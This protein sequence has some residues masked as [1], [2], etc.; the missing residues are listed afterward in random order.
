MR[1]VP[2]IDY[3]PSR[4]HQP[5]L[6]GWPSAWP[7][8]LAVAAAFGVGLVIPYRPLVTAGAFVAILGLSLILLY[9]REMPR[10]FLM[11]LGALL[12][13]YAFL[14]KGAAY[15]GYAPLFIGEVVLVIGLL[16]VL[17]R[18]GPSSLPRHFLVAVLLLFMLH[19][20]I[21]T[22]PYIPSYGLVAM[23][24]AAA[25]GY[26]VFALLVA[27]C[28]IRTGWLDRVPSLYSRL[29]PWFVLW[30]PL[31]IL[32]WYAARG[33]IPI[34]P[35][36]D[37][38]S[39]IYFK[40]GDAQVH[41]AG[42]AAFIL[43][44]LY[45]HYT[46]KKGFLSS[47]QWIIWL[48]W[49]TG[50]AL[51][52]VKNRGGMVAVFAALAVVFLVRPSRRWIKVIMV[53]L[54]LASAALLSNLR[55]SYGGGRELSTEQ[56][57]ANIRSVVDEEDAGANLRGTREWRVEWWSTIVSY[58]VNGRYFWSGK[59]YGVNLAT[60]DKIVGAGGEDLRSPHNGHLTI[61][62]RSGVPG[63]LLWTLLQGGFALSLFMAFRRARQKG[64][65]WW[66][67]MNLWILSY[68][69]AFIV[70]ASFDVYLEGPMGGIW[71]WS[72]FGFGLT[73]IHCQRHLPGGK[74]LVVA[75]AQLRSRQRGPS[76]PNLNRWSGCGVL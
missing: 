53:A 33:A 52:A 38:I 49:L 65:E 25:W 26:G 59:G 54:L 17:L 10:V 67:K 1:F 41:L 29:V 76:P 40:P 68:W 24:D 47:G 35:G 21:R 46:P 69:T 12:L 3:G 74:T 55:I 61:L 31:A 2:T 64:L 20:A 42:V 32:V 63:A 51:A 75:T 39:I 16:A 56:F 15:I 37:D 50:F 66:A 57:I 43:V 28:V 8:L 70:N 36:S 72:L 6:R 13:G 73:V 71:F 27:M 34:I 44:G 18:A 48:L 45:E 4:P 9:R 7:I 19:G 11:V 23:R 30:V 5:A 58:T 62:A 22:V 60:S 14:D